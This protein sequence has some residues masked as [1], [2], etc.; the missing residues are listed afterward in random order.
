MLESLA[1]KNYT[2]IDDL[3]VNFGPHLN[4]ISGET[5]AGKSI[6]IGALSLLLG[7]RAT[8]TDVRSGTD[9]AEL[10]AVISLVDAIP[11]VCEWLDVHELSIEDDRV[12][13]RR[14]I[15][16]NGRSSSFIS[17]VPVQTAQLAA[18]G[19]K[20]F[21]I[22]SQHEHQ[23]LLRG[24]HQRRLLDY[25]GGLS[26]LSSRVSELHEQLGHLH[27]KLADW[28]KNDVETNRQ[29]ELLQH[30]LKEISAADLNPTEEEQLENEK[31]RLVASE[32]ISTIISSVY[33]NIS[34]TRG[35][36]VSVLRSTMDELKELEEIEPSLKNHYRQLEAAFFEV[37][38]VAESIRKYQ[39]NFYFDGDR[40]AII[41]D[42]LEL[43]NSL[44][45]KY[46]NTVC[47]VVD[48][49]I[50]CESEL[51]ELEVVRS[52]REG[53]FHQAEK[54]AV[55]L[56]ES[57]AELSQERELASSRLRNLVQNVLRDLGM[58]EVDFSV[59]L[60]RQ[61]ES[62]SPVITSRGKESV[63]FLVSANVGEPPK[64]LRA[65]A[66]GGEISRIMLAL[67]SV[68]ADSDFSATLVFDE[69]D[70]GIGGSVAVA[71]GEKLTEIARNRQ[72]IC[73][74]HLATVAVRAKTHLK[75]DKRAQN[76]RTSMGV[77]KVDG[78]QR[79]SEV[80][81]MLSGD[82]FGEASLEHAAD[83]LKKVA[84]S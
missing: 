72:V 62:G 78:R 17:G 73:I 46:G 63:D 52:D 79:V 4:V 19:E 26:T 24:V 54:V 59:R 74:T 57:A 83:L 31:R 22:H 69:V 81:R 53:V 42:R 43:I 12:V 34:E 77:I 75:V 49:A 44:K 50:K 7:G 1:V 48:Y 28:E 11:E 21:D 5:G 64:P 80:A 9:R 16:R 29:M 15:R 45:R 25:Y 13:L 82:E 60:K 41:S 10:I 2:L 51:L 58:P 30:A 27:R 39:G 14:V 6:V 40:L 84:S 37:E 36:V 20:L 32:R 8:V 71:V 56:E 23:L 38:D 65:I 68:F 70:A 3:E 55:E 67:K 18:L 47:E 33:E 61:I 76:G 35:G 66:S